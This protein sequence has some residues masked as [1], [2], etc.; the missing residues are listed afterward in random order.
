MKNDSF[1]KKYYH[2]KKT[3]TKK[4]LCFISIGWMCNCYYFLFLQVVYPVPGINAGYRIYKILFLMC[5]WDNNPC[6]PCHMVD[7]PTYYWIKLGSSF[8]KGRETF[9]RLTLGLII[10]N[11]KTLGTNQCDFFFFF[12]EKNQC[13]LI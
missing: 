12:F 11:N 8:Y 9:P 10:S 1:T 2:L 6:I 4:N 7:L 3:N 13:D 5:I